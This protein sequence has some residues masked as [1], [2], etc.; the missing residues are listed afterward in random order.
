MINAKY[1][2]P[3]REECEKWCDDTKGCE[4]ITYYGPGTY[5]DYCSTWTSKTL[6]S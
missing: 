4:T 1:N 5:K 3:T 6:L 2:V